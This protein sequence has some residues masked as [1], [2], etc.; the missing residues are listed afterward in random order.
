M[1]WFSQEEKKALQEKKGV[2]NMKISKE[3]SFKD[4]GNVASFAEP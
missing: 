2:G 1:S 4:H 3:E